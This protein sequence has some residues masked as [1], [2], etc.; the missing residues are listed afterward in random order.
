MMRK[1]QSQKP[2]GISRPRP[3]KDTDSERKMTT[4]ET[5]PS[6]FSNVETSPNKNTENDNEAKKNIKTI[7]R[8]TVPTLLRVLKSAK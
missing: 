5:A 7:L 2:K 8:D 6:I 3:I 4:L 1:K